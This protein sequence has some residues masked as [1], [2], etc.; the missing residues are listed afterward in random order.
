VCVVA[1]S[2]SLDTETSVVTKALLCSLLPLI[3]IAGFVTCFFWLYRQRL[4][5]FLLIQQQQQLCADEH[6]TPASLLLGHSAHIEASVPFDLRLVE[7]TARG[8]FGAV[9]KAE[10]AGGDVVAVK[11]FPEQDRQSW[12]SEQQFYALPRTADCANI[13]QFIGAE[14]RGAELWLVTEYHDIGS[15]YDYLKT[16]TV[17]LNELASIALSVSSGLA[18]LHSDVGGKP[19]VAHRDMKSRNVLLRRDMTACI[20]DFGLVLILDGQP[21]DTFSQVTHP[22]TQLL[23]AVDLQVCLSVLFR[24]EAV[25]IYSRIHC[26]LSGSEFDFLHSIIIQGMKE[27]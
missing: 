18:F 15:L 1:S 3:V 26:V 23:C 20:A 16:H 21:R 7:L 9:W 4:Q 13:L 27:N 22:L 2:M 6:L 11:I 8:R 25:S 12:L 24:G 10:L 19:S 17:S 14:S 5:H